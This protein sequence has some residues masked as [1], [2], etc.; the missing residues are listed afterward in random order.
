M[1]ILMIALA[2]LISIISSN[3]SYAID[4]KKIEDKNID[5]I[6]SLYADFANGNI[7]S[8]LQKF[9]SKIVWNDAE[10]FPYADGNPYIGSEA[11]L[12]GVFKRLGG[13]WEYWN[14]TEQKYYEAKSGEIIVTGRYKAK[15]KAT[16]KVI[17]TEFVHMW[18]IEDGMI[19][20]FQQFA[21]TYQTA[22]AMK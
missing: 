15:N 16:G 4:N 7:P 17:N 2:A 10:N 5:L 14:L 19:T 22:E 11:V 8:V 13:E 9:D 1:K 18:T 12:E 21:D 20:K 3:F 6:Q